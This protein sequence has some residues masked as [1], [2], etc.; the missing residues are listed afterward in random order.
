MGQIKIRGV[1]FL[2]CI[3]SFVQAKIEEPVQWESKLYGDNPLT[4]KI[5]SSKSKTF[6]STEEFGD[7]IL[8]ANYLILGEKHDN[9]DH[10][11]LQLSIIEHLI[12]D[13]NLSLLAFEM[14][15]PDSQKLSD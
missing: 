4:G 13:N 7:A 12:A 5:W 8:S 1:I 11:I 2:L 15:G 14:M 9:P 3:S 10:H 6:L